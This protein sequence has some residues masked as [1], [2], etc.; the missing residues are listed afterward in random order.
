MTQRKKF[1]SKRLTSF[2]QSYF[3]VCVCARAKGEGAGRVKSTAREGK[4]SDLLFR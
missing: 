3:R 1:A 2:I 4:G